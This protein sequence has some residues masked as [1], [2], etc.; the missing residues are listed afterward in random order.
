[1]LNKIRTIG[2]AAV[3]I[4]AILVALAVLLNILLGKDGGAVVTSI[5]DNT[6][7]FLQG[8]PAG[9]IVGL[10]ALGAL[11]HLIRSRQRA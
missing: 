8:L 2:W 4:G 3:E 5:A 1:M 6:Q 7:T 11:F 10:V 9:T